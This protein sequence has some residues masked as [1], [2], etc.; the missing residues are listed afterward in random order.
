MDKHEKKVAKKEIKLE[1][2]K[3]ETKNIIQFFKDKLN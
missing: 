1:K 3:E 2:K